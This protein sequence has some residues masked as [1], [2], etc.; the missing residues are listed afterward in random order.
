[1][2]SR[3]KA[4]TE[5]SRQT[6]S[7]AGDSPVAKSEAAAALNADS[8]AAE[9]GLLRI[10]A[11]EQAIITLTKQG[12]ATQELLQKFLDQP[13]TIFPPSPEE[14]RL[15]LPPSP[16]LIT[17]PNSDVAPNHHK[18]PQLKPAT[19]SDFDSDCAKG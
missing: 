2:T 11:L 15:R 8:N 6:R 1:M 17:L 7:Q 4:A 19:P 16:P 5:T 10:S 13:P 14:T 18:R 9:Q 3:G 12:K